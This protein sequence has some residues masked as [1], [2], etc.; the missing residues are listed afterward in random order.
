[1][2]LYEKIINKEE[3]VSLVGLGYVGM[4]I[5]IEFAARGVRVIGYDL[6]A[7]KTRLRDAKFH[8]VAVPTPVNDDHT[9]DLTPVEGVRT[10][11]VLMPQLFRNSSSS[12]FPV[13]S[14]Q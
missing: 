14:R 6:N 3:C 2:S 5:A 4:P 7:A 8:I 13:N 10:P 11:T 9:P 12:C 1:M